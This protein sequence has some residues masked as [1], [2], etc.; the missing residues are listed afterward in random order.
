MSDRQLED[1]A[2]AIARKQRRVPTNY[3]PPEDPPNVG[4]MLKRLFARAPWEK[5]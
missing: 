2:K 5:K 4:R 1:R 3:G